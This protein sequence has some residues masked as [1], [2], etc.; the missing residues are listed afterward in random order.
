[1]KEAIGNAFLTGLAIVFL[2]LIMLLL[3]SSLTYS[4]AYK[5]KNKIVST[6]EKYDGFTAEAAEEIN[7]NLHS[8][9]YRTSHSN[10]KCAELSNADELH[11][12][13]MTVVHDTDEGD[14]HYCLYEV[15]TSRGAY[16]HAITFMQFDIPIIGEYLNFKVEGDSRVVYEGL[17]G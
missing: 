11:G 8:I 1:M 10:Q 14:Y 4:K 6:I 7:Q 17:V 3:I 15:R 9:G 13:T 16:F 2:S 12:N 5:A